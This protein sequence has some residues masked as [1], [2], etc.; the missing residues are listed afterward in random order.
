MRRDDCISHKKSQCVLRENGERVITWRRLW[1]A[2]GRE[3][4]ENRRV[5]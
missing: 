1:N 5:V 3:F 4:G 2:V